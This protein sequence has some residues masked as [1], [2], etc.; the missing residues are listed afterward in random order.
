MGLDITSYQHVKKVEEVHAV[1]D[2]EGNVC[3]EDVEFGGMG[4]V[5]TFQEPSFQH[6]NGGIE[7]DNCYTYSGRVKRFRAG[8]YS[9]YGRFREELCKAALGVSCD[10]LWR[11]PE[12]Y[13]DE[14]FFEMINFSDCEGV[15][16]F[17]VCQQLA[18]DFK[19]NEAKVVPQLDPDW[20]QEKYYEWMDAFGLAAQDGMV[21]FH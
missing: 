9:G 5:H 1:E 18:H 14:P 7:P 2:S 15:I 3:Y 4:H 21:V 17:Q 11:E 8:S 19:V 6:A 12:K 10:E 13:K 16:G 20:N